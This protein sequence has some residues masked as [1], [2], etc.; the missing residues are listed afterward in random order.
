MLSRPVSDF[1]YT[2]KLY[3]YHFFT[4]LPRKIYYTMYLGYEIMHPVNENVSNIVVYVSKALRSRFT[5]L[6]PNVI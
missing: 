3:T 5:V 4:D 2:K 6:D 1:G